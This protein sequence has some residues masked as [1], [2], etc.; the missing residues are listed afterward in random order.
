ML[1]FLCTVY[2]TLLHGTVLHCTVLHCIALFCFCI[3]LFRSQE[4]TSSSFGSLTVIV[5]MERRKTSASTKSLSVGSSS[6][7]RLLC[8]SYFLIGFSMYVSFELDFVCKW[9][10][11]CLLEK[12]MYGLIFHWKQ[13]RDMCLF[14]NNIL[15]N[16]MC[17]KLFCKIIMIFY[18]R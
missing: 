16:N 13:I 6:R 8:S 17:W 3:S 4:E 7:V 14:L 9:L 15:M 18:F 10:S 12:S 5:T 1:I 2:C 11:N